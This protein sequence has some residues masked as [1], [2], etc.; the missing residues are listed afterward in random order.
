MTQDSQRFETRQQQ[1][2]DDAEAPWFASHW[3]DLV[4]MP[5]RLAR[6]VAD[7]STGP[8]QV[9]AANVGSAAAT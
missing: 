8:E 4:N 9:D 2:G 1:V 3:A 6:P 7:V 5:A